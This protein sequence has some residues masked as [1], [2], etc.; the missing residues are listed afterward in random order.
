MY[1]YQSACKLKGSYY[2]PKQQNKKLVHSWRRISINNYLRG[3][4]AF[5]LFVDVVS[6]PES[7]CAH[8]IVWSFAYLAMHAELT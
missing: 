4:C 1:E 7:R 8:S 6:T 3:P 2:F 5:V